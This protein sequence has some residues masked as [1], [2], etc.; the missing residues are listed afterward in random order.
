MHHISKAAVVL[1]HRHSRT[2]PAPS[3]TSQ[4]STGVY[5]SIFWP[6][7]MVGVGVAAHAAHWGGRDER[8]LH[9]SSLPPLRKAP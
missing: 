1:M 7:A 3:R 6:T 2:G 4:C 5:C 8:L 9:S